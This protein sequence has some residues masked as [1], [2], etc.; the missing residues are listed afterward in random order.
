MYLVI[1]KTD[2]YYCDKTE[3]HMSENNIPFVKVDMDDETLSDGIRTFLVD[4]AKNSLGNTTVPVILKQLPD[5]YNT[6]MSDFEDK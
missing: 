1:G 2:C 4:L 5:G 6:L 3:K